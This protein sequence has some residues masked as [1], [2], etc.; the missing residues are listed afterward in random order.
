MSSQL[1][2]YRNARTANS[3]IRQD[4]SK[5]PNL[6]KK[7]PKI[8]PEEI[9]NL[10]MQ[11]F[12]A[13]NERKQLLAKISRMEKLIKER[14]TTIKQ[15]AK[16]PKGS[17]KVVTASKT[18]INQLQI[19]A[20]SLRRTYDEKQ[21]KLYQLQNSDKTSHTDELQIDIQMYS[22]EFERLK[23]EYNQ[24]KSNRSQYLEFLRHVNENL[25]NT[26]THQK[27]VDSLQKEIT[28]L[29]DKLFAYKS[30]E[31]RRNQSFKLQSIAE[32]KQTQS[33]IELDVQDE[34]EKLDQDHERLEKEINDIHENEKK[35]IE[36]IDSILQKQADQIRSMI[37]KALHQQE[38]E[39]EIEPQNEEEDNGEEPQN[40]E[41]EEVESLDSEKKEPYY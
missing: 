24:A 37:E 31:L 27:A 17:Q 14:R 5:L 26:Q 16:Q 10:K 1:R 20:D 38:E 28:E 22:L 32:G 12:E 23:K 18:Q 19:E 30:S 15:I 3:A 4:A 35:N 36:Y 40:D 33:D 39:S 7:A 11:I 21:E 25:S 6:K 9:S 8:T 34:I 13:E 2:S 41:E 29:T